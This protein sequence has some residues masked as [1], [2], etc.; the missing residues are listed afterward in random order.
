MPR[1]PDRQLERL[2]QPVAA[3]M[4]AETGTAVVAAGS[5]EQH[6]GHLP[7]GTDAF[8]A[9]SIAE[10]V[11]F[12]LNTVV[13]PLGPVG[14]APYHLPWPGSLS[15]SPATLSAVLLDVCAALSR[16]GAS[17]ILLVN[18]HEGNSATLRVAAA[19]AQHQCQVRIVIAETHVITHSMY[20]DEMEFTHA[21]SMETAAV[22]AYDPGLVQLDRQ[23]DASDRASGEAAHALFRR[24]DVYPVLHDFRDIAPTGWYGRP[25]RADPDRAEEIAEAVADHVVRRAGEIWDFLDRSGTSAQVGDVAAMPPDG[26]AGDAVSAAPAVSPR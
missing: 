1:H 6:G 24:P 23:I 19:Q 14:V 16:A 11:A 9:Q 15:L 4:L 17:R 21:G 22:L 18:W 8:A 2:S 7:L 20:P 5:V 13:A 10:R 26:Y 3:R 25:E 12:R